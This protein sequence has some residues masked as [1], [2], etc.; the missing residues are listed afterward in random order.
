VTADGLEGRLRDQPLAQQVLVASARLARPPLVVAKGTGQKPGLDPHATCRV[1]DVVGPQRLFDQLL[2]PLHLLRLTTQLVVEAQHLGDESGTKPE[3]ERA[4]V[5][6]GRARGRL[7]HHIALERAQAAR[8]IGE[9]PVQ[10]VVQLVARHHVGTQ[11]ALQQSSSAACRDHDHAGFSVLGA[12][13]RV[14]GSGF[15]GRGSGFNVRGAAFRVRRERGDGAA[16][17]L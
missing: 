7:G 2:E 4:G 3:R 12:G 17:C 11:R 10:P 14:R 1:V 8:R 9:L 13:F 5:A 15:G 16:E 6:R